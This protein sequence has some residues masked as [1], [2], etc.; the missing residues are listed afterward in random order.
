[1]END[2]RNKRK[3]GS[4]LSAEETIEKVDA[5]VK[6]LGLLVERVNP[7]KIKI[8]EAKQI[9]RSSYLSVSTEVIEV[10]PSFSLVELWKSA[11]DTVEYI[12]LYKRLSSILVDVP[13]SPKIVQLDCPISE[14]DYHSTSSSCGEACNT[15]F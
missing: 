4:R 11:G 12:K 14:E 8:H 10:A 1:M 5:A 6:S 7:C 3:F 15:Q 13:D 2:V 9:G